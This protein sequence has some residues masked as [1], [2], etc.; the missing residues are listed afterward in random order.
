MVIKDPFIVCLN[1]VT[2]FQS[3]LDPVRHTSSVYSHG[4]LAVW[5]ESALTKASMANS[6]VEL[7]PGRWPQTER[8]RIRSR[9][10]P[11]KDC[12]GTTWY[13]V[14][15]AYLLTPGHVP[16]YRPAFQTQRRGVR[17]CESVWAD[18][19]LRES[20]AFPAEQTDDRVLDDCSVEF[21]WQWQFRRWEDS[22]PGGCVIP[23]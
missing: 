20:Q 11:R 9:W 1:L 3:T 2:S 21:E 14:A 16:G 22:A 10:G 6:W 23:C 18:R 19:S 15:A 7:G 17:V 12:E 8:T 4:P 13:L 5:R